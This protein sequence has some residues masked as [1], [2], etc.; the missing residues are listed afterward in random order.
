[1]MMKPEIRRIIRLSWRVFGFVAL[2]AA[3]II[4]LFFKFGLQTY[5][6]ERI[7]TFLNP[8]YSAKGAVYTITTS[9]SSLE[10]KKY[11][12]SSDTKVEGEPK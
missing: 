9:K 4:V 2:L 5:Q 12:L 1:M 8:S 3:L 7:L 10:G 6:Q 11:E